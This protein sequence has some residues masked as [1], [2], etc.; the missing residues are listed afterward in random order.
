MADAQGLLL[1]GDHAGAAREAQAAL[2][3]C[4]QTGE[5]YGASE[6]YRVI[7]LI[8]SE[9]EEP[10]GGWDRAVGAFD[11][12]IGVAHAQRSRWL[13]LRAAFTFARAASSNNLRPSADRDRA[14]GLLAYELRWFEDEKEGLQTP[15]VR[16]ARRLLG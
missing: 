8:A 11:E 1:T 10:P 5:A 15:L 9:S 4:R 16:V 2:A 14:R 7:G 13:A 12:A 3:H 6:A